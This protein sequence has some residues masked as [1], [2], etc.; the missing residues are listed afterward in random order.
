M[1]DAVLISRLVLSAEL[2]FHRRRIMGRAV[3]GRALGLVEHP[4]VGVS[5][6]LP[7]VQVIGV[8]G[9]GRFAEVVVRGRR[10]GA[11]FKGVGATGVGRGGYAALPRPE[12]VRAAQGE[13]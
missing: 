5:D 6:L 12:Q 2:V 11:P 13:G 4:I 10:R 9:D 7:A 1:V 8:A 3:D